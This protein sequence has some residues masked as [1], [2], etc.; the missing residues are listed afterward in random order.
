M[1]EHT[2]PVHIEKRLNKISICDHAYSQKSEM[3]KHHESVHSKDRSHNC[4]NCEFSSS[5]RDILE[6]HANHFHDDR[7]SQ[8]IIMLWLLLFWKNQFGR[9]YWTNSY[10][11]KVENGFYL[12]SLTWSFTIVW[13]WDELQLNIFP[14]FLAE[15]KIHVNKQSLELQ[16]IIVSL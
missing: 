12:W 16:L 10:Q 7:M 9:S 15:M 3:W 2:K 5:R 8:N 6:R 14:W 1:K 13:V 11:K 4:S